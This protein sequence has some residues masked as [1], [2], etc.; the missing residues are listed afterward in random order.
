MISKNNLEALVELIGRHNKEELTACLIENVRKVAVSATVTVYE[1]F[2]AEG[3]REPSDNP[4]GLIVRNTGSPVWQEEPLVQ[5]EGFS[6]CITTKQVV[7]LSRKDAPST[8]IIFPVLGTHNVIGLLVI[9]CHHIDPET[10]YMIEMLS[11]V[12]KN[13]HF[14]LNRNEQD[15]L[16]GLYNR[17]ALESRIPYIFGE[18]G[19]GARGASDKAVSKCVAMLDLD[20][21]KEVNDKYGHLFGDEVLVHFTRLMNH[22]FRPYDYLFRYG[23]EEF[24]VILQ[25]VKLETGLAILERFCKAVEA[26]DFP[27]VGKK[28][29]SI[30]VVQIVAG[31]LPSTLLDKAD[32]ALYYA[33]QNGRNRVCAYEHLVAAGQLQENNL[34]SGDVELF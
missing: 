11:R 26:Y 28:T 1:V 3:D 23:G 25:N 34:S 30:G 8:R 7:R 27:Q 18:R 20:K 13:Q 14:L 5:H 17:Q 4:A 16:T 15:G 22:S 29:V 2:N 21:F 31:E 9:D 12:W 33:K 19:G 6:D 32:K 10:L 24:V